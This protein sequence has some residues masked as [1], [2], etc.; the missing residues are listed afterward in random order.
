MAEQPIINAPIESLEFTKEFIESSEKMGFDTIAAILAYG[1]GELVKK[2]GFSYH[3][4]GE[5]VAFLS[6]HKLIHLLQPMPGNNPG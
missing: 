5:L 1:R 4:L 3:W 2:D 6:R